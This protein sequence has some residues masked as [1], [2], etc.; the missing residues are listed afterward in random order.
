MDPVEALAA[1]GGCATFGS[2]VER[3]GRRAIRHSLSTGAIR[4]LSRGVYA[5]PPRLSDIAVARSHRG[6]LSHES[7]ALHWGFGVVNRPALPHV[8]IPR[9]RHR[10]PSREPVILHWADAPVI[11]DVTTPL[12]TVVDCARTLPFGEALA[13]ADSAVRSR[14]VGRAELLAAGHALGR[15]GRQAV[16]RVAEHVD[17]RSESVLES[18]LRAVLIGAGLDGF[19]PQLLIADDEFTARVDLADP[20]RRLILEADSFEFHGTRRALVR[21]CRRYVSLVVRGWTVLRFTWEDV[22]YE[23]AWV[24][25]SVRAVLSRGQNS[26]RRAA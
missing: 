15:A 8:T 18:M 6:V 3:C 16:I 5:L 10:R 13:I 22:V 25:E 2:L 21:D 26:L 11:E 20:V 7:A 14:L 9:H 17:A 24:I 4:R 23:P 12:R 1:F 19:V